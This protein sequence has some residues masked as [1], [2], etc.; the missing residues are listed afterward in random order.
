MFGLPTESVDD[1]LAIA[2]LVNEIRTR[3]CDRS[4]S[5][6]RIGAVTVSLNP[7]SPKPWT[8]FQWDPM[9]PTPLLKEKTRLLR[10]A[11]GRIANLS[12]DVESPREAYLSTLLSRGDRRLSRAILAVHAAGGDWWRVIGDWRRHGLEDLPSPDGYVHRTYAETEALPWDFID[13]RIA[14]SYLWVERR[15]AL[16][17]RQTAPCD[18][19]TCHSCAAC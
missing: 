10:R 6:G 4:R 8:P 12:L 16:Q 19:A 14:K 11:C 13:H 9:E 7:F 3:L 15:R 1:V 17:A 2:D 5:R 18:T